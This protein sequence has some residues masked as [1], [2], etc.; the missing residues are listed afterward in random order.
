MTNRFKAFVPF[1]ITHETAFQKGHYGDYKYVRTERDKNDPG[2]CTRFGIDFGEH[3][4]APWN[5]TEDQI[6][7]LTLGQAIDIYSRHW[8][9]DKCENMPPG[10]GECV[11]NCATMSGLQQAILIASRT[12]GAGEF[13]K[14]ENR[15]FDLIAKKRPAA[16]EYV[17]GWKNRI[18]DLS[19]WLKVPI[20]T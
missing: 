15:V 14:D 3:R 9:I 13:M 7:K 2:G 6:D 10:I 18:T 4:H 5:M 11:F 17:A 12:H 1:I 20:S 16:E 19:K 8:E